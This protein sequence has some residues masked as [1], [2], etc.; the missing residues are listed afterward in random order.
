[1]QIDLP[2]KIDGLAVIYFIAIYLK[3]LFFATI[4]QKIIIGKNN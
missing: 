1:M 4:W 2:K 3:Y